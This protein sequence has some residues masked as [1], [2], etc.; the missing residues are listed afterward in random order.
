MT[1]LN[2]FS[3]E[4]RECAV[5]TVF[6]HAKTTRSSRSA[7]A[8]WASA[9]VDLGAPIQSLS[10]GRSGQVRS[11]VFHPEEH[12]EVMHE[13]NMTEASAAKLVMNW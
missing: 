10:L 11:G 4:V 13:R 3:P 7:N 12:A 1:K 6:E 9:V 2:K 8:S 5:H